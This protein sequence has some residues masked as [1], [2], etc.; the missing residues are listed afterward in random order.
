MGVKPFFGVLARGGQQGLTGFTLFGG[1]GLGDHLGDFLVRNAGGLQFLDLLLPFLGQV[2]DEQHLIKLIEGDFSGLFQFRHPCVVLTG[3]AQHFDPF[4][5][6]FQ[7]LVLQLAHDRIA[8]DLGHLLFDALGVA[9]R[10]HVFFFVAI[11]QGEVGGV[12]FVFLVVDVAAY[13]AQQIRLI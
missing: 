12:V 8:E 9:R 2:L 11:K 5:V 3:G 1:L 4:G 6:K 13:T 10:V 7:R